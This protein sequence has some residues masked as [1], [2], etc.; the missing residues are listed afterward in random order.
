CTSWEATTLERSTPLINT[1]AAVSSQELSIPRITECTVGAGPGLIWPIG[2]E[3]CMDGPKLG[4][5]GRSTEEAGEALAH[6][7]PG[8]P[9]AHHPAA[10]GGAAGGCPAYP[11]RANGPRPAAQCPAQ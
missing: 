11:G 7:A 5:D 4:K 3:A 8:V 6:G 9:R 10:A 1:A 2:L